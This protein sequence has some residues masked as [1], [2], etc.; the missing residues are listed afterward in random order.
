MFYTFGVCDAFATFATVANEFSCDFTSLDEI[1]RRH[2]KPLAQNRVRYRAYV[3]AL[4]ASR[5]WVTNV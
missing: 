1:D 2:M 5:A 3:S 4:C